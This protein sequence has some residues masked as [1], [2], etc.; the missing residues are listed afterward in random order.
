M[1]GRMRLMGSLKLNIG[2]LLDFTLAIR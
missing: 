1:K 2:I